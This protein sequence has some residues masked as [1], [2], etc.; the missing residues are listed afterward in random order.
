MMSK[1]DANTTDQNLLD[2]VHRDPR[3]ARAAAINIVPAT[4]GAAKASS[5]AMPQLKGRMDG[6]ALRVPV[7]DGSVTDLVCVVNAEPSKEEI[8]QAYRRAAE[9]GPLAGYLY[10]AEDPIVSSDI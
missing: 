9:E 4:T 5:L 6:F 1:V 10:Y 2:L 3:R 7:P 8:N